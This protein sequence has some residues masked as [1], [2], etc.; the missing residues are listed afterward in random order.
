[1][2]IL[3][4]LL[5]F[6]SSWLAYSKL[7]SWP[8]RAKQLSLSSVT[9]TWSWRKVVEN[10]L[11]R[12]LCNSCCDWSCKRSYIFSHLFHNNHHFRKNIGLTL[13]IL[14]NTYDNLIIITHMMAKSYFCLEYS[15]MKPDELD[16]ILH[17][18]VQLTYF[19]HWFPPI[20]HFVPSFSSYFY[21]FAAFYR[22]CYCLS[23][24]NANLDY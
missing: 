4:S 13:I 22:S 5:L 1:M 3:Y 14:S 16:F 8:I 18:F 12:T 19:S 20:F 23:S 6:E 11:Y 2:L 21:H 7:V 15:F 10:V 17:F 9:T 24:S